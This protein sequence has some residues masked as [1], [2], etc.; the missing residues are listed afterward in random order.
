[1]SVTGAGATADFQH[2]VKN[3]LSRVLE[4]LYNYKRLYFS[5]IHRSILM[6]QVFGLSQILLSLHTPSTPA[7]IVI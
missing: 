1:M 2:D 5:L 7:A 3:I 6:F 4:S